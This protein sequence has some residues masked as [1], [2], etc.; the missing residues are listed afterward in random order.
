MLSTAVV[1][2]RIRNRVWVLL[3]SI[4]GRPQ[5]T[6]S[7]APEGP[8]IDRLSST[9]LRDLG[10]EPDQVGGRIDFAKGQHHRHF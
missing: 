3:S 7:D 1:G 6:A 2:T 10:F 5:V 4:L 8:G 9:R